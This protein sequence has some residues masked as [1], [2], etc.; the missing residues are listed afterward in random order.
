M[1]SPDFVSREQIAKSSTWVGCARPP[2]PP[3]LLFGKR[4]YRFVGTDLALID[5]PANLVIDILDSALTPCRYQ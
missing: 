3:G 4:E 2:A 5:V 1:E